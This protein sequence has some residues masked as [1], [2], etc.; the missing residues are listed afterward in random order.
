LSSHRHTAPLTKLVARNAAHLARPPSSPLP[1]QTQLAEQTAR[2]LEA[3]THNRLRKLSAIAFRAADASARAKSLRA[4]S[5]AA[6]EAASARAAR[7]LFVASH[8]RERQ[9]ELVAGKAAFFNIRAERNAA[10]ARLSQAVDQRAVVARLASKMAAA[11]Y[12]RGV[13]VRLRRQKAQL[14]NERAAH[15]LERRRL[16]ETIDPVLGAARI[17]TEQ[18]LAKERREGFVRDVARRAHGFVR[19]VVMT[20]AANEVRDRRVSELGR[21]ALE[22]RL[23]GAE[24][25]AHEAKQARKT[26]SRRMSERELE[27]SF[28][29]NRSAEGV[30]VPA[31]RRMLKPRPATSRGFRRASDVGTQFPAPSSRPPSPVSA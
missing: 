12:L 9:L 8:R 27:F 25:R 4:K 16:S 20:C 11:E 3:A 2:K 30:P 31:A 17:K 22:A 13:D 6:T 7:K 24:L 14:A 1:R 28:S 21:A 18:Q 10:S 23:A 29:P 26:K 15:V 19:R 5:A